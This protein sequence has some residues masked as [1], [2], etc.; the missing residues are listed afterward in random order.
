MAPKNFLNNLTIP[1]P[2]T[3]DWD[4]MIG[5]DQV[6]FCEHCSLKVHNLSMMTRNQAQRLVSRS[7]GRLCV[8]Y[9]HDST[10]RPLVLP[11]GRK[12]HRIGRRVSQIAAGAFTATLSV[13]S[14]VAQNSTSSQS[15]SWS[16]PTA[17]QPIARWPLGSSI[18]GTV[19]DQNGAVIPGATISL[20]NA[21]LQVAL[22][23]DDDA[24]GDLVWDLLNAGADV[25]LKDNSGATALMQIAV[26]NNLEAL[27]ALLDA[28]AEVN[29]KNKLGQTA[30]MLAAAEGFVNNVRAL[31]L[32]GA[33]INSTDKDDMNALAHASENDHAAVIRFL[34]AK[35][36]METVAHEKNP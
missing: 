25:N 31:V 5:N 21:D 13:T 1:S 27:K 6:R 9:H 15:G 2:C 28:G 7:N 19:T 16:P 8:R 20:S 34:K 14:A 22:M 10:G 18:A 23:L 30:L 35:G 26:S 32:A 3:A 11:V 36:A 4:S 33:D 12:L 29:G 24:T 17:A